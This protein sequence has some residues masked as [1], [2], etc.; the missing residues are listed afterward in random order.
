[1]KQH[2]FS[3]LLLVGLAVGCK[4]QP[5][6]G[7]AKP[8]P[9]TKNDCNQVTDSVGR[10]LVNLVTARQRIQSYDSLCRLHWKGAEPI[11]AYTIRAVDLL[12]AMGLPPELADSSICRF[13]HIRVYLGFQDKVGFKLY[14]VPVDNACMKGKDPAKW[15]AGTDVILD[16]DANP[17]LA[18][19]DSTGIAAYD[20]YV[21]D[22][23]A[24]CPNTCPEPGPLK[25][26]R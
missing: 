20:K 24:P 25:E 2:L 1:M 14:V 12:A 17:I 7:T 21:L 4:N 19:I 16:K 15:N 22:L 6:A 13:K 26:H 5:S 3:L 11:E 9:A 23:N 8:G 10:V 18:N